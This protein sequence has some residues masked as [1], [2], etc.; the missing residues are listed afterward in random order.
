M[1]R[2]LVACLLNISEGRS[3]ETLEAIAMSALR[4]N[5]R[6]DPDSGCRASVLNIFSDH[7]YNRS[8]MTITATVEHI[9]EA[10][11]HACTSAYQLID[12]SRH[13]G[14]HPRL[15]SVDLVP[16]HPLSPGVTLQECGDIAIDVAHKLASTVKGSASFLFGHADRP[17]CRP[18]AQRRREVGWFSTGCPFEE[19]SQD[20]GEKPSSRYGITAIGAMPYMMVI[21]VTIDTQDL[22]FGQQI[23]KSIRGRTPGGLPGVQAMAFT[24]QG[25]VEIACNIMSIPHE[26]QSS[27]SSRIPGTE[28]RE[29]LY[30][31]GEGVYTPP[32][33]VE[34]RI[35]ELAAE[36]GVRTV[37]TTVV[38]FTPH[39]ACQLA[40]QALSTGQAM[41][42]K[43]RTQVTM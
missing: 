31:Y 13:E 39:G 33:V 32:S 9:G 14:G 23:V 4:V 42:W 1:T 35:Q 27:T 28:E 3:K 40:E 30:R 6:A 21:N 41:H 37:G 5:D 11:V 34:R 10:V 38:G 20:I 24:H 7:E 8:S 19:L 18:L 17:L 22:K 15:G 29:N 25:Q 26:E 2:R 43:T 36:E 16:F 12:M